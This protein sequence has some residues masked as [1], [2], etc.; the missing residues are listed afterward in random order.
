[1][2]RRRSQQEA[3]EPAPEHHSINGVQI[4]TWG[5]D[6]RLAVWHAPDGVIWSGLLRPLADTTTFGEGN[7]DTSGDSTRVTAGGAGDHRPEE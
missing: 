7:G 4:V 2:R 3:A 1:M 5:E 6:E